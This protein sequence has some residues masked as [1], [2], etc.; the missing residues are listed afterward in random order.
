MRPGLPG[1]FQRTRFK[2]GGCACIENTIDHR[3]YRLYSIWNFCRLPIGYFHH[4]IGDSPGASPIANWVPIYVY[5]SV[6]IC[7]LYA[8]YECITQL[9]L[10]GYNSINR[11]MF[12]YR[13]TPAT[14]RSQ[15]KQ[16][17]RSISQLLHVHFLRWW[18][19]ILLKTAGAWATGCDCL[20]YSPPDVGMVL[21]TP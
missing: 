12:P 19:L 11:Q 8:Y 18:K 2:S 10:H 7:R 3:G 4:V 13:V 6:C 20:Y 1:D 15:S 17:Y 14:P 5:M 16:I 9:S 21:S